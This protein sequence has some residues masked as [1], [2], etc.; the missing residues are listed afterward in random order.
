[1]CAVLPQQDGVWAGYM[2][3]I[4]ASRALGANL[5]SACACKLKAACCSPHNGVCTSMF[6]CV[7]LPAPPHNVCAHC[8]L[9]RAPLPRRAVYQEGQPQWK[10]KGPEGPGTRD[11]HLSYHDGMVGAGPGGC[12]CACAA[13]VVGTRDGCCGLPACV[14]ALS[15]TVWR[16]RHRARLRAPGI[17]RARAHHVMITPAAHAHTHL[18]PQHYNSVRNADDFGQGPPQ[19]I[20]LKLV[21]PALSVHL[22]KACCQ[23]AFVYFYR[24]LQQQ[25]AIR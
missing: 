18:W 14:R 15:G 17:A 7:R 21:R 10:I 8:A 11:L 23:K 5:T 19:P 6:I 4:A 9:R 3:T 22:F 1:M 13:S 20:T 24:N 2:E 12:C 25:P 16:L